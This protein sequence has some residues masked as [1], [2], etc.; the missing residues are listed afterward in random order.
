MARRGLLVTF[1]GGEGSGKTTQA[2]RLV[3]WLAERNVEHL[4]IREPGGTAVGERIRE[5]LLKPGSTM[6]AKCEVF[7]FLAA[8]S[9]LVHEKILPALER[10]AV[11]VVDRFADSTMA[12]QAYGRDLPRRLIAIFNRYACAGIRPDLTLFFDID[13]A[14]GRTRGKNKDRLEQEAESYHE[15]VRDAYRLLARRAKKRIKQLDGTK[16][17]DELHQQV[18]G[19]VESLFRRKGF[20]V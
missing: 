6:N 3:R 16:S 9:Q 14:R 19:H 18:I 7:L 13:V 5:V 17:V 20:A 11:V 4:F 2:E 10:G 15:R 8:R 12:Y 1:E